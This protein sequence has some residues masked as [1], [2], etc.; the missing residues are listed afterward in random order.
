MVMGLMCVLF[1][2]LIIAI[3]AEFSSTDWT[4]R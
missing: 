1:Y 2:L 3:L 4:F